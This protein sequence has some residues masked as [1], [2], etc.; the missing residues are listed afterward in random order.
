MSLSNMDSKICITVKIEN[1][2][3]PTI[4]FLIGMKHFKKFEEKNKLFNFNFIFLNKDSS[5]GFLSL[6]NNLPLKKQ[7]I[8]NFININYN[9][10]IFIIKFEY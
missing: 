2:F 5:V 8:M 7:F 6:Q 4:F 9:Q 3:G 1:N 10:L